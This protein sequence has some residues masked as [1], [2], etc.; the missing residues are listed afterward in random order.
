VIYRNKVAT[1]SELAE[2]YGVSSTTIRDIRKK[3]SWNKV[4]NPL[5]AEELEE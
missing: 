5:D 2:Q 4:T 1:N 3:R